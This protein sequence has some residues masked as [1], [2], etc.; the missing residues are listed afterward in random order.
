MAN[1]LYFAE[2]DVQESQDAIMVR[3]DNFLGI[4]PVSGGL[5]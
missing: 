3:S 5:I 4:D 2:A 1:Y